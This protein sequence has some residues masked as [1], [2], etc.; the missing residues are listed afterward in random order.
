MLNG[1]SGGYC[2]KMCA[3]RV[4]SNLTKLCSESLKRVMTGVNNFYYQSR[5]TF[6][7]VRCRIAL[8]SPSSERPK[9]PTIYKEM[10]VRTIYDLSY[11]FLVK[12]IILLLL[13]NRLMLYFCVIITYIIT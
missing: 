6:L 12:V 8:T 7:N 3:V 5:Q 2:Y 4:T 1:L 13:S 10:K 9:N 11:S